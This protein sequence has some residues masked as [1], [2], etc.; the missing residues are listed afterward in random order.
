MASQILRYVLNQTTPFT[1]KT[2]V[3]LQLKNW[4]HNSAVLAIG[5]S[6]TAAF[7]KISVNEFGS[8]PAL[9]AEFLPTVVQFALFHKH[10]DLRPHQLLRT[11]SG[12]PTRNAQLLKEPLRHQNSANRRQKRWEAR[13]KVLDIGRCS[14]GVLRIR[15]TMG[16]FGST[17][18]M[19]QIQSLIENLFVLLRM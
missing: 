16:K 18:V 13:I 2:I 15:K 14:M 11:P 10:S 3:D 7:P 4:V 6:H 17:H 5:P 12:K 9:T 1:Q 8:T 19:I